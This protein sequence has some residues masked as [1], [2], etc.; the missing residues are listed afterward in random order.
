VSDVIAL[1][2]MLADEFRPR[3]AEYDRTGEFPTKNY[4]RMRETGYLRSPVPEEL[5]GLGAGIVEMARAQQALARGCASTALAVN[6]HL[7]QVGT[8]A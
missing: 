7:F 6:M 2:T 8:M 3:A 5:G 1:A 4:E